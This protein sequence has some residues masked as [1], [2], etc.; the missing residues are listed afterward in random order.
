[1]VLLHFQYRIANA[2]VI[3][4]RPKYRATQG[5]IIPSSAEGC[6]LK[7]V[8]E[9]RVWFTKLLDMLFLGQAFPTYSQECSREK[10]HAHDGDEPHV[11]AISLRGPGYS[12][13]DPRIRSCEIRGFLVI[14]SVVHLEI[15][16]A[17]YH[18]CGQCDSA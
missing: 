3:A 10:K 5:E 12:K 7:K 14:R 15:N 1:M 9:N 8:I 6:Q 16:G 4:V 13:I 11:G 18:L 17:T 2:V